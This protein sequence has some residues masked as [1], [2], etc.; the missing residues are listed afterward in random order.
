LVLIL[1]GKLAATKLKLLNSELR[2][3]RAVNRP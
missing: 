1:G 2:K 3:R